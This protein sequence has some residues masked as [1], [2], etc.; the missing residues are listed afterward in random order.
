MCAGTCN[1][2]RLELRNHASRRHRCPVRLA[3]RA[4]DEEPMQV[5]SGTV[6][7]NVLH[8][9]STK[10]FSC[11]SATLLSSM[12]CVAFDAAPARQLGAGVASCATFG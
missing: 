10:R 8:N 1:T 4:V 3:E 6:N 9:G 11:D 2:H 12:R 5:A 7:V